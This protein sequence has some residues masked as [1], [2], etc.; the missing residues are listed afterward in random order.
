M[1]EWGDGVCAGV[2]TLMTGV[3]IAWRRDRITRQTVLAPTVQ[4]LEN[5]MQEIERMTTWRPLLLPMLP[6]SSEKVVSVRQLV[7]SGTET[8]TRSVDRSR[9]TDDDRREKDGNRVFRGGN[10]ESSRR[11]RE[12]SRDELD[13]KQDWSL[14]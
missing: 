7:T 5:T 10:R 3:G 1:N 8:V 13:K 14:D 4:K 6:R 12:W 2:F 9:V 11:W